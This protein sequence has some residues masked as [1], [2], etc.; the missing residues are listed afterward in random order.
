VPYKLVVEELEPPA[1]NFLR[2]W[3]GVRSGF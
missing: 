3:R 2:L 1:V